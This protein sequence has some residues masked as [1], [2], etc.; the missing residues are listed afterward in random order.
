MDCDISDPPAYD[1]IKKDDYKSL[2]GYIFCSIIK[3]LLFLFS[4]S[5]IIYFFI[6]I[7]IRMKK[8]FSDCPKN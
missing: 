2:I 5:S 1:S 4:L 3:W 6:Y 7:S 8:I